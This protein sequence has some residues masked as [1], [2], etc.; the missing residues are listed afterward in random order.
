MVRIIFFTTLFLLFSVLVL[1]AFPQNTVD[2]EL[3]KKQAQEDSK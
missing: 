3:I 1:P 2:L